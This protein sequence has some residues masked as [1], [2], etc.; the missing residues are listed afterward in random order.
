MLPARWQQDGRHSSPH[1]SHFHG[2]SIASEWLRAIKNANDAAEMSVVDL[3]VLLMLHELPS[4]KVCRKADDGL[5]QSVRR[6]PAHALFAA[7]SL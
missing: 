3:F 2:H 5:T 7:F 4:F 1:P 6:P